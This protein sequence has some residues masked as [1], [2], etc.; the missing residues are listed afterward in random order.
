MLNDFLIKLRQV[1]YFNFHRDEYNQKYSLKNFN[2]YE[3][4][5]FFPH[6]KGINKPESIFNLAITYKI[7]L[8]KCEDFR[9]NEEQLLEKI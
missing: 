6:I 7:D 8:E 5:N 2:F 4:S 9:I 3:I 1:G